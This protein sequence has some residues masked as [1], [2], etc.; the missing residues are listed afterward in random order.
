MRNLLFA[1]AA[2]SENNR[3]CSDLTAFVLWDTSRVYRLVVVVIH[4][5]IIVHIAINKSHS[6]PPKL[7]RSN[8]VRITLICI[9]IDGATLTVALIYGVFISNARATNRNDYKIS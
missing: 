5:Y 4:Y 9:V 2:E 3:T 8:L 1:H 6:R 7:F